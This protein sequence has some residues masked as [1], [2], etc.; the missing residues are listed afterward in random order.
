[1]LAAVR[2]SGRTHPTAETIFQAVRAELPNIGLG[3]VYRNLQRLADDGTIGVAHLGDRRVRFDPTPA[4][5]DHFVCE[6]CGAV[7]DLD[8]PPPADGLAAAR[9][10]GHEPSS[11]A[12]VLFGRCRACRSTP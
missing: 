1:M 9:R 11:Y 4:A 10:A 8:G 5:H 2:A 6:S 3:T 7:D 12:L